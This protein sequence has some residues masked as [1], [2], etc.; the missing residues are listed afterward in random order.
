[1][2]IVGYKFFVKRIYIISLLGTLGLF[3]QSPRFSFSVDSISVHVEN[4]HAVTTDFKIYR[5]IS[6][7]NTSHKPV[8]GK[9][10]REETNLTFYPLVPLQWEAVYTLVWDGNVQKF[11][12]PREEEYE[13]LQVQ[14]V[15]PTSDTVPSN[16][17]KWY[18]QFS[19]PINPSKIYDH[20]ALMDASGKEVE[21]AVL[22]LETPLLSKD[23]KTL[24]LWMEP[25]RQKRDLGPNERLGEVMQPNNTYTLRIGATLKDKNG[26]FL[27]RDYQH[28]FITTIP[29]REPP[30]TGRWR[31][32]L[33][34]AGA[35][36]RLY[37][38]FG[39]SLD[40]GSLHDSF[41]VVTQNG[42]QVTGHFKYRD[43]SIEF[44]PNAPWKV[45]MYKLQFKKRIEDV[46]G[47]N[48]E[49]PFDRDVTSPLRKPSLEK[50]FAIEQ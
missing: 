20:I 46:A 49:R 43:A 48:L 36:E 1:M 25:G 26:L 27:E 47:N 24:T 41:S 39:E 30:K 3:A 15:Y 10:V 35:K 31:I 5:G 34:K 4:A 45:G 22:P 40:F 17:L 29:D 38:A 21:R 18:V 50:K 13:A 8:L 16:L 44:Y 14:A 23:G 11:S 9:T 37:I 12:I 7:P 42:E 28:R 33:P 6:V 32:H 2:A 19:R